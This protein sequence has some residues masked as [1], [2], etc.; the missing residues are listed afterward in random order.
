MGNQLNMNL[1]LKKPIV[2]F[3]LESTGVNVATD[4]IIEY[5]FIKLL[6]SGKQ[7]TLKGRVNP[8]IP[9]PI[10]ASL[11][12]GIYD[13][14]IKN[15]PEFKEVAQKIFDFIASSDLGGYNAQKYDIPLLAE[16]LLRCGIDFTMD[17]R[18]VVDVQVVFHKMEQRTLSAAYKFYCQKELNN[19]HS[20]EHDIIATVEILDKQ[21][22]VYNETIQ[23]TVDFLHD[24]T[25]THKNVDFAGR[26]VLND[27]GIETF[28]FGKHKGKTVQEV[29][30]KEPSYYSWMMNGEFPLYTKKSL[31]QIKEKIQLKKLS[32]KF[33]QSV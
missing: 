28:N 14:D 16:E 17:D 31:T 24:F 15:E 10:E 1:F 18:K 32:D 23:N 9:I 7:E 3:D 33:K 21:L 13:D 27:E 30:E 25:N 12:H 2:F 19:A 26:I 11:I 5:A 22:E 6:P 29:L 8:K 4:K 20:A